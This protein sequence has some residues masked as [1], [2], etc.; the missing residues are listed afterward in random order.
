MSH[1]SVEEYGGVV[2][3]FVD[4]L[5]LGSVI[6][7]GHSLGG[8]IAMALASQRSGRVRGL[9]LLA[10][11]AKL[12]AVDGWGERFLAYLP[13]PVRQLCFFAMAKKLLFAPSASGDAVAIGMRELRA[14]RP[15]T[16]LNDVHAA[17]AM[18]LTGPATRLDV[19]T[20]ILVGSQDRLTSPALAQHL[21]Q[22]IPGS[23][24]RIREGAGHMLLL[25]VPEWVNREVLDFVGSMTA[26]TEVPSS[27]AVEGQ[28]K[29]ALVSRF[30]DW[31]RYIA[32]WLTL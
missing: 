17:K 9:V 11:C 30:L 5:G 25:E 3:N 8:A 18:D 23:L 22:L 2:A 1:V 32:R 4:A 28:H 6:A 27:P 12:P 20:L 31:F 13:G 16:I 7:V 26:L 19:P 10:S 21:N 24:L 29:G 14:C 15:E